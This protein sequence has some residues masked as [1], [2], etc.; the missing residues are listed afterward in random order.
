MNSNAIKLKVSVHSKNRY[1]KVYF[2]H[3]LFN[4]GENV[5]VVS[6]SYYKEL[7]S[8]TTQ[9]DLVQENK[10]LKEHN[11][12]IAKELQDAFT[13]DEVNELENTIAS[14]LG[15]IQE[16]KEDKKQHQQL[17]HDYEDAIA[18]ITRLDN[19]NTELKNTNQ[20][21]NEQIAGLKATFDNTI[22]D[23]NNT[24][25]HQIK[26]LNENIEKD[27]LHIDELTDKYQ[28]L[29]PLKE[30]IPPK[31]HYHQLQQ[32][33]DKINKI[34]TDYNELKASMDSQ[35]QKLESDLNQQHTKEKASL[36]VTYNKDINNTKQQYNELVKD[37]N[38]LL[39]ELK[40]I[41]RFNALLD[42]RHKKILENKTEKEVLTI[43]DKQ[44][45]SKDNLKLI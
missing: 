26:E 34:T 27:R 31:E 41:T 20:F 2:P 30:Y 15:E 4:V 32:L 1:N 13:L 16:L 28:S 45:I 39:D 36:L 3:D 17:I 42:N 43:E 33:Q 10:Q 14:Y 11:D 7:T 38:H 35:I 21:L 6:E 9:Q 37:Y 18:D 12:I 5:Y 44:T 25:S 24:S 40:T 23:I 22:E 29:L 8:N 19:T